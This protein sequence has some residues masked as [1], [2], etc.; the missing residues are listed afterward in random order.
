MNTTYTASLNADSIAAFDS[1]YDHDWSK[2]CA[3]HQEVIKKLQPLLQSTSID[4]LGRATIER[5]VKY[6]RERMT[7]LNAK[8]GQGPDAQVILLPT[9]ESARRELLEEQKAVPISLVSRCMTLVPF[10]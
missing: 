10:A 1:E 6:H 5:Q 3:M 7:I 8:Q 9:A 2:S 4:K